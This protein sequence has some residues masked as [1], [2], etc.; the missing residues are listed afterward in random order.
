M[1]L[2]AHGSQSAF[3]EL[4]RRYEERAFGYFLRR[5]RC[6]AR[7]RDLYQDLFLRL[8][9]FRHGY[10]PSRPFEPWFFHIAHG[11]LVDEWRRRHRRAEV[12]LER[13]DLA[14]SEPDPEQRAGAVRASERQL[15]RLSAEEARILVEAKMLGLEYSEI[16]AALSK[17]VAAVK[18]IASRSLRRLRMAPN[19][20]D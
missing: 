15:A 18:Q 17:S 11:V 6:E 14:S 13:A 3:E 7:A 19:G 20:A 4:F 5:V 10:D 2:Y 16:A 1:G 9:R 12:G 8:H